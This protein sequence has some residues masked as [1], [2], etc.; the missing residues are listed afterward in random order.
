MVV[1]VLRLLRDINENTSSLKAAWNRNIRGTLRWKI[2]FSCVWK[3][4]FIYILFTEELNGFL[5]TNCNLFFLFRVNNNQ[6]KLLDEVI[7]PPFSSSGEEIWECF[8]FIKNVSSRSMFSRN[9]SPRWKSSR[10]T[11][12]L[13]LRGTCSVLPSSGWANVESLTTIWEKE[14]ET[15]TWL[16]IIVE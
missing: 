3:N 9:M 13:F 15:W 2:K 1:I 5:E 6:Q 7:C 16:G 12:W 8:T 11:R 14:K 10:P 4:S